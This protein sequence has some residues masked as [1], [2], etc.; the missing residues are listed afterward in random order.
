MVH[1]V[2][3]KLRGKVSMVE[4]VYFSTC[5]ELFAT[6]LFANDWGRSLSCVLT[7]HPYPMS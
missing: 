7:V 3:G 6:Q 5:V 1:L 2:D 4:G